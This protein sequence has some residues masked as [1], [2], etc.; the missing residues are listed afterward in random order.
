MMIRFFLTKIRLMIPASSGRSLRDLHTLSLAGRFGSRQAAFA[1]QGDGSS[2]L[3][4]VGQRLGDLARRD[5][6]DVDR[7]GDHIGRAFLAFRS[8]WHMLSDKHITDGMSSN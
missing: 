2:V 7:V 3:A 8:F 5:P 1:P 4:V 6:H